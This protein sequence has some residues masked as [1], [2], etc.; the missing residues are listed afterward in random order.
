VASNKPVIHGPDHRRVGALDPTD[1][2]GADPIELH[3]PAGLLIG[4]AGLDLAVTN[5][6]GL[7]FRYQLG[8]AAGNALDTAGFVAGAPVPL[9]YHEYTSGAD[10]AGG[11]HSTWDGTQATTRD[12]ADHSDFG[13]SD[14]GCVLFNYKQL[15]DAGGHDPFD[16]IGSYSAFD[17]PGAEFIG[18]NGYAN[19]GTAGNVLKSISVFFKATSG[20]VIKGGAI[21]GNSGYTGSNFTGWT[22]R[23]DHSTN[24]LH[25]HVGKIT[26]DNGGVDLLVSPGALTPGNWYHCAVTWDGTTWRMYLNGVLAASA[27][28]STTPPTGGG[29]E[30]GA[31]MMYVN[32]NN[33]GRARGFFWG[34][35]DEVDGY[36]VVL[37]L[38]QIQAITGAG[39]GGFSTI[40]ET[41][42]IGAGTPGPA[43]PGAVS[44]GSAP[45]GE[46]L[47]SD[48]AGG[49]T[50]AAP[51]FHA[52]HN[53]V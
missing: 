31:N 13:S 43:S 25:F 23:Y 34:Q 47:V 17:Y 52:Y 51:T 37:T 36:N 12:L 49:T 39:S 48:G 33:A 2:G 18:T 11:A 27:A 9:G 50:F 29:L 41:V 22:L 32:N 28:S 45:L 15:H 16:I 6:G 30:I 7:M 42:T 24:L 3:L 38:A 46:A 10:P 35:V 14:D 20:G 19:W 8:E 21:I 1:P 5:P 53:G 26:S 40:I 4:K 44:S